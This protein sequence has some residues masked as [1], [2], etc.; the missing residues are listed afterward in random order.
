MKSKKN[1]NSIFYHAD[2]ISV[3]SNCDCISWYY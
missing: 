1:D 3:S 2:C